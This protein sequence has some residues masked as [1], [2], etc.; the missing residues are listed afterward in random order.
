MDVLHHLRVALGMDAR[1]PDRLVGKPVHLAEPLEVVGVAHR[2]TP[3]ATSS[4][5]ITRRSTGSEA[6]ARVRRSEVDPGG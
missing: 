3:A 4:A 5:E 1:N 6:R 2:P